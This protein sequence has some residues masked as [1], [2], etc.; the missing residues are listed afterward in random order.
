MSVLLVGANPG[1][2]VRRDGAT[3]AFVSMWRVDWSPH[4][5][6]RAIVLWHEGR[7]GVVTATPELGRWL[8]GTFTRHFPEVEGLPWPEPVVTEA[9]VAFGLDLAAGCT[10]TGGEVG[11]ELRGPSGHRLITVENFQGQE[12][13]LSTVY[14]KCAGGGLTIGGRPVPGTVAGFVADAEVWTAPG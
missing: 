7:T 6:G 3:V 8:A 14:A 12:L 5:A 13:N 11:V 9:P 1:L 10:V 4:G 2:T